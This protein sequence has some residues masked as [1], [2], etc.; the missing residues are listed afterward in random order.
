MLSRLA[1][2]R[3]SR[4]RLLSTGS[5]LMASEPYALANAV[6]STGSRRGWAVWDQK[7]ASVRVSHP[8]LQ[9]L[10]DFLAA[11]RVDYLKHEGLFFEVGRRSD[12]LMGAFLWTTK[13]G[14]GCGGI[15]LRPYESVEDYVR[16]GMRLAIGMGRKSALAGL[17]AGGAKG[18]IAQQPG[19]R[20]NDAAY[21]T[22]LMHD[23]G[24]FLTSLR[25]CYVAAE[26]AGLNVSD[27]DTVFSKTRFMTCIS[28]GLGGSG[29]PSVPTDAGVTAAMEG[30]VDAIGLGAGGGSLAGLRVAVQG[31]GNVGLPL[32]G[33]LLDRGATV[34]ASDA[35]EARAPAP[36]YYGRGVLLSASTPYG[37][38]GW[39]RRT[40]RWPGRWRAATS[41]CGWRRRATTR[42]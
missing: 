9:P 21:R 8:A 4:R 31:A 27:C 17:W 26:D 38:R 30:A 36:S 3:A 33:N 28:A 19:D 24:D 32:I 15:R 5:S 42:S 18:V 37:R 14:Q 16:D 12:A 25:G 40:R 6:L 23:Y 11:D 1:L 29:N 13:R 39:R 7:T 10:G 2:M 35:S 34:V 41:S 22:E 20:H